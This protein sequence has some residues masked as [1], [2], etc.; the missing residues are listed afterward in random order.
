MLTNLYV[1]DLIINENTAFSDYWQSYQTMFDKVKGNLDIYN[2][3]SK[4][5]RKIQRMAA[6]LYTS[7]INGKLYEE[8]LE[9]LREAIR[10][11]MQETVFK[12]KT[13]A[14]KYLEYIE[15]KIK[16]VE[17]QLNSPGA[18][19]SQTEYM[20]LLINYSVYRKL[21]GIEDSKIYGKIWS[22]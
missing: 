22:L 18:I 10:V 3:T 13:F 21:F 16:L 9:G 11:D 6:R 15:A 8:Y 17:A 7:I 20:I 1:I 19:Q 2:M 12:N 5:L 14:E 4:M